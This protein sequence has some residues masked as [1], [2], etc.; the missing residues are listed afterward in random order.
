MSSK[1][2]IVLSVEE[3][4]QYRMLCK[5]LRSGV[6]EP[7]VKARCAK[8]NIAS[9]LVLNPEAFDVVMETVDACFASTDGQHTPL[10]K[11]NE[12]GDVEFVHPDSKTLQNLVKTMV[13]TV[14]RRGA[15]NLATGKGTHLSVPTNDLKNAFNSIR[16]VQH[17]RNMYQS[18]LTDNEDPRSD[19]ARCKRQAFLEHCR[20]LGVQVDEG[21]L[22]S[23]IPGLDDLI[24]F[25]EKA[26]K[27][28]PLPADGRYD[29]EDLAEM[30]RPGRRCIAR[31]A[32]ATGIDCI[33]LVTWSRYEQ[34]MTLGGVVRRFVVNFQF[35]ACT[36]DH[37]ALP[38]FVETLEEF[39]SQR[40]IDA[41]PFVPLF[42]D[43]D[44][45]LGPHQQRGKMYSDLA[46][47]AKFLAYSKGS[48]YPKQQPS[49]SGRSARSAAR[50]EGRMMVDTSG[51]YDAGY[52][53]S[54][55][56]DGMV[57]AIQQKIKEYNVHRR[58][59]R[60]AALV[61]SFDRAASTKIDD[62]GPLFLKSIPPHLIDLTWPTLT[63]FSFTSKLWGDVLVDGLFPINF[64][65]STFDRLVL[66]ASR[67][68]MIKALV[69][70][71]N[72]TFNDIVS[73]KGAGVVFLLYGPPGCGEYAFFSF[74]RLTDLLK[75]IYI[76]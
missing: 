23:T 67:K 30:F 69:R 58:E 73:G 11:L 71:S 42:V 3:H 40:S 57:S 29:F 22:N 53:V 66:P 49:S 46:L 74:L 47:M 21:N 45:A 17:A 7:A 4:E 36:G 34:G 38:E 9:E 25:I 50:G 31:N 55:G 60:Q 72:D 8:E 39:E 65:E 19:Q 15:L 18:S 32:V 63:G 75:L 13:A 6:P 59:Q 64:T 35:V 20:L 43:G 48:F 61:S 27:L 54:M 68:R 41:L 28:P 24:L 70:H 62:S 16:A 44:S 56:Y 14:K 33:V 5:L 52:S 51:A 1:T 10:L 37:F 12:E 2:K 76:P 26:A